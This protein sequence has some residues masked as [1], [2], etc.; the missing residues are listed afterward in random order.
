MDK[1]SVIIPIH[2]GEKYIKRIARCVLSQTY[3]NIELI[4]VEN[5]SKDNSLKL[6]NEIA[7]ADSRVVVL[8]S[9]ESGTSL[10]RKKGIEYAS[11]KYIIFMDQDDKY[12]NK[13]AIENMHRTIVE[14]EAQL[15]QFSYYVDYGY[16]IKKKRC[17]TS[18]KNI[19]SINELKKNE[20]KGILGEKDSLLNST[21]W[22]KI[23]LSK[24]LKDAIQYVDK[25]LYF[26][27][28]VFLNVCCVNS[29]S[30]KKICV[31]SDG[32]Y[33]WNNHVGFSSSKSSGKAL[34]EDYEKVKPRINEFLLSFDSSYSVFKFFNLESIYFYKAYLIDETKRLSREE[35]IFFINNNLDYK[36]V[37]IAKKFF[38]EVM[39]EDEKWDGLKFLASFFTAEAFYDKFISNTK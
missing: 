13:T 17:F 15:C 6:L 3:K 37:S 22:S 12:K 31:V 28:D 1:I 18:D 14:N 24:V 20:I 34:M 9:K 35:A 26:A 23:Y 5:F 30:L 27:E 36:F 29:S 10:A 7:L 2:N 4:M 33:I 38:N 32:Y 21:V 25:A 39:N 16:F 11:G 8:E 19:F